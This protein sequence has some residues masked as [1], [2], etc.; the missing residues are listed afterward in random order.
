MLHSNPNSSSNAAIKATVRLFLRHDDFLDQNQPIS[1]LQNRLQQY[2][3]KDCRRLV[4]TDVEKEVLLKDLEATC[5]VRFCPEANQAEERSGEYQH[6]LC[7]DAQEINSYKDQ[8]DSFWFMDYYMPA[9][10]SRKPDL[11]KNTL[12]A[13]RERLYRIRD[14][15]GTLDD[16]LTPVTMPQGCLVCEKRWVQQ[17]ARK[18]HLCKTEPKLRAMDIFAGC[19]GMSLG[20]KQSGMV[21]TEY[22]I[23]VDHDAA[24]TFRYGIAIAN[25]PLEDAHAGSFR[26]KASF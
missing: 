1:G 2:M 14:E 5:R 22:S 16:Q 17:E 6:R 24:A 8:P 13:T 23:E 12:R 11:R 21:E 25:N 10:D 7:V 18:N 26:L 19:G 9:Q 20:L 15:K 4:L 3:F